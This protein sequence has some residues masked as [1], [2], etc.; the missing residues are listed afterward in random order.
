VLKWREDVALLWWPCVIGALAFALLGP[1]DYHIALLGDSSVGS[2]GAGAE[3]R[4]RS[5]GTILVGVERFGY[6]GHVIFGRTARSAY[7][8]RYSSGGASPRDGWFVLDVR[9]A[10]PRWFEAEGA[11]CAALTEAGVPAG[12]LLW[13]PPFCP[14]SSIWALPLKAAFGLFV[15]LVAVRVVTGKRRAD[16]E[17]GQGRTWTLLDL[18]CIPPELAQR[19]EEWRA[20][21]VIS[22]SVVERIRSIKIT[23]ALVPPLA[24]VFATFSRVYHGVAGGGALVSRVLVT[25]AGPFAWAMD[26]GWAGFRWDAYFISSAFAICPVYLIVVG[27]RKRSRWRIALGVAMWAGYA[28]LSVPLGGV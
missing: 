7:R 27:W 28:L 8:D 20:V 6:R 18:S 16:L 2:V 5:E 15:L 17:A 24:A 4:R 21:E 14:Y 3:L 22:D 25:I 12:T 26:L 13:R 9:E 19:P 11:W 10:A 1:G 23:L